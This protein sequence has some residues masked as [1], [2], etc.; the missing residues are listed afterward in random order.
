MI[1]IVLDTNVLLSGT[2]WTGAS[3]HIL[4]LID[5]KKA[6]LILSKQIL[7]EYNRVVQSDEIMD[8]K[9]YNVERVNSM[10]K[11]LKKAILV[12]P[13]QKI[14]IVKDDPDDDKFI[15]AAVSGKAGFILSQDN[16]LLKLKKYKQI[17]ILLPE[18]FLSLTKAILR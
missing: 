3:Y 12:K 5:K 13:E 8:K 11:L 16:H 4:D 14:R 7:E 15:E 2:F 1:R 6:F 10:A 18:E 9:A 17:R